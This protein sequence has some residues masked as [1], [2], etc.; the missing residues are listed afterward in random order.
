[1]AMWTGDSASLVR[2][3]SDFSAVRI[4]VKQAFA[5]TVSITSFGEVQA[6]GGVNEDRGLFP[7]CQRAA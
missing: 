4:P 5:I 1:M 2:S 6:V 7:L 3:A